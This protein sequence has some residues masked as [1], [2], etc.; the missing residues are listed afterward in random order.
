M[1]RESRLDRTEIRLAIQPFGSHCVLSSSYI[2]TCVRECVNG[3]VC[4]HV[5]VYVVC[6]VMCSYV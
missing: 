4:E 6:V 3:G 5:R 1:K 2:T